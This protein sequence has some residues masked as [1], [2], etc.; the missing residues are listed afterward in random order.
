MA[1]PL[2]HS[3]GDP[4]QILREENQRLRAEVDALARANVHAAEL[5]AELH[6]ARELEEILRRQRAE[7]EHANI[8]EQARSRVLEVIARNLGLGNLLATLMQFAR[9]RLPGAP[10]SLFLNQK[11]ALRHATHEGLPEELGLALDA[12]SMR[13]LDAGPGECWRKRETI[14]WTHPADGQHRL[15]GLPKP[16]SLL[17]SEH[18]F[19]AGWSIPVLTSTG[20]V[21]GVVTLYLPSWRALAE[22][23]S[24]ALDDLALLAGLGLEQS[25]L[26][27][28]LSYQA[29]YDALTALPNRTLFHHELSGALRNCRYGSQRMAVLWLD[30]DRFKQVNDSLGHRIGDSLLKLVAARL[31]QNVRA[32]DLV[33]RVGGDEFVLLLQD[34]P[35]A[36]TALRIAEKLVAAFEVPF[37][38]PDQE[39]VL[40]ASIGVSLFPEH[41]RT[42]EELIRNSDMAMYTAKHHGRHR[43]ALFSQESEHL[44]RDR[45]AIEVNLRRAIEQHELQ[46][47]FQPQVPCVNPETCVAVEALLRWS[48]AKLGPVPPDRFIPVAEATGLIGPLGAWVLEEACRTARRWASVGRPVRMAVNIAGD[49]FSRRDFVSRIDALIAET[50]LAPE[51]LELELTESSILRDGEQCL[52]NMHELRRLGVRLAIDDF[53]TGYSSLSYLHTMPVNA[54]KIDR[55]FVTKLASDASNARLVE[56]I[57]RLAKALHLEVVA[58]GVETP[59]QCRILTDFGCDLI[60]GYHIARPMPREAIEERL[61]P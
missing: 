30:M 43:V 39:L 51:L 3:D 19:E 28:R 26:Y 32:G 27:E 55:S 31:R 37:Q 35:D 36:D 11:D 16:F 24:N 17:C 60:Q 29:H 59:E 50:G 13:Q 10:I 21:A 9:A 14:S 45:F 58:E 46:L 6:E 33:A 34:L 53:G 49:Q 56:A 57:V 15:P 41:G 22:D 20:G 42:C 7:I 25:Q 4:Y 44:V 12:Y 40:S 47:H 5:M 18:G 48:S 61:F 2:L 1:I 52:E 38:L 23:E 8:A 54:V